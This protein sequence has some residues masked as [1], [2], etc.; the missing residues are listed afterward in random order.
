M[1]PKPPFLKKIKKFLE[2]YDW[3]FQGKLWSA[4]TQQEIELESCSN[5]LKLG[6][7]VV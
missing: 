7:F 6:R 1:S 3:R 2:R 5:P 4:I